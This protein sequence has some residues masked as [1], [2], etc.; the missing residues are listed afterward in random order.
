MKTQYDLLKYPLVIEPA[1]H[2]LEVLVQTRLPQGT[3]DSTKTFWA[4]FGRL[5][6]RWNYPL[7]TEND[8]PHLFGNSKHLSRCDVILGYGASGALVAVFRRNEEG[9][10]REV[11]PEEQTGAIPTAPSLRIVFED[12]QDRRVYLRLLRA[13]CKMDS[14]WRPTGN[15]SLDEYRALVKKTISR[16]RVVHIAMEPTDGERDDAGQTKHQ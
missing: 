5:P 9:W 1:C 11:L 16:M 6:L 13:I 14:K 10:V 7:P 2:V 12:E 4:K 15:Q 8:T 3:G